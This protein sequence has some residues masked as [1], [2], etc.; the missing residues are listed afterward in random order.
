MA[1][2]LDGFVARLTYCRPFLDFELKEKD[3]SK[4]L[5]E[6]RNHTGSAPPADCQTKRLGANQI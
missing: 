6:V 5:R 2:N 4:K 3:E 1:F